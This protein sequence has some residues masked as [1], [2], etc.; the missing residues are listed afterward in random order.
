LIWH[1]VFFEIKHLANICERRLNTSFSD[2][3]SVV[4]AHRRTLLWQNRNLSDCDTAKAFVVNE[5]RDRDSE[6]VVR[7]VFGEEKESIK[8]DVHGQKLPAVQ[9]PLGQLSEV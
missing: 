4:K 1:L 9:L 8:H 7:V 5:C 3:V 6:L 2:I